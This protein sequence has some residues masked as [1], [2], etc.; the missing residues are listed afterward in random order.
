MSREGHFVD[1]RHALYVGWVAGIALRNGVA[2]ELVNDE[3]G[4]HTDRLRLVLDQ[5]II[6]VVVPPPPEDWSLSS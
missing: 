3:H 6:D 5:T 2:V 4:N 1:E